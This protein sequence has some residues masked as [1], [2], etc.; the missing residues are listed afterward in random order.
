MLM[1]LPPGHASEPDATGDSGD[2]DNQFQ[3]DSRS[4]SGL[5]QLAYAPSV[6]PLQNSPFGHRW[7]A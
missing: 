6:E 3:P 1:V 2:N 5:S 4:E 7:S